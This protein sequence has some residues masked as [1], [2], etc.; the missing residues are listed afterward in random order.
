MAPVPVEQFPAIGDATLEASRTAM[1]CRRPGTKDGKKSRRCGK[2]FA[3][4]FLVE[5]PER[6]FPS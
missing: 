3:A 5:L 4:D 6:R 2:G 1:R